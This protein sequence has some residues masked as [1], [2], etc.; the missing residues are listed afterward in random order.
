MSQIRMKK[1]INY[2][3]KHPFK[4]VSCCQFPFLC[5]DKNQGRRREYSKK[6]GITCILANLMHNRISLLR[7][8]SLVHN[9][10]IRLSKY[11]A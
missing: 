1:T 8:L 9:F 7:T 3:E 2:S 6:Q 11:C 5:S 10:L 4:S